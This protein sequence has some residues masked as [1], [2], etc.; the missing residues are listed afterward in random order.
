[1]RFEQ[2]ERKNI[3]HIRNHK[4]YFRDVPAVFQYL[5]LIDLDD[6]E[7]YGEDRWI[8]IGMLRGIVVRYV[9]LNLIDKLKKCSYQE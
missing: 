1:M 5:V 3:A 6:R 8:G 4:L 7:D 2:D 9:F